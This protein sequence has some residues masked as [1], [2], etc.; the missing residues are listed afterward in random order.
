MS[1][2][3][4]GKHK[5]LMRQIEVIGRRSKFVDVLICTQS[6]ISPKSKFSLK[7]DPDAEIS[8]ES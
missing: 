6:Q 3:L 5:D 2:E 7:F 4:V 8:E 1:E